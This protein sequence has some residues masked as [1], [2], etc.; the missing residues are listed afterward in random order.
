[1]TPSGVPPMPTSRSTPVSGHEV[2]MA[3]ATSPS[4]ISRIRAPVLRTEAMSSA[5][6]GRSRM[7]T[8]RS[9]TEVPLALATASRL[10]SM[11]WVMSMHPAD[12]GPTASFSM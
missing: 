1:M 9:R 11:D 10:S 2:A 8:A 5:C 3:P 12:R 4:V 7:A 6:R